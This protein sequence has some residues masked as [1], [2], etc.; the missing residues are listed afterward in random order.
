MFKH[1][2]VLLFAVSIKYECILEIVHVLQLFGMVFLSEREKKTISWHRWLWLINYWCCWAS[3]IYIDFWTVSLGIV[4]IISC[5]FQC[6]TMLKLSTALY[7]KVFSNRFRIRPI[8]HLCYR[9]QL[10][11]YVQF[12]FCH[13]KTRQLILTEVFTT[14]SVFSCWSVLVREATVLLVQVLLCLHVYTQ[15]TCWYF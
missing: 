9:H 15:G 11:F 1:G 2:N 14:M 8:K 3:I 4:F 5:G 12:K 10:P 6:E 13:P 7:G